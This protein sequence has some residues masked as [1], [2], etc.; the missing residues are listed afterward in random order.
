MRVAEGIITPEETEEV[1]R[2]VEAEARRTAATY[3]E[4]GRLAESI[5]GQQARKLA[6]HLGESAVRSR[7]IARARPRL[8]ER[9]RQTG[10][11]TISIRELAALWNKSGETLENA[12]DLIFGNTPMREAFDLLSRRFQRERQRLAQGTPSVLFLLSDGEP[13]DGDPLP[14]ASELKRSGVTIVSCFVTDEDVV[15]PRALFTASQPSWG[16]GARLMFDLASHSEP[17]NPFVD[18]LAKQGWT[19]PDRARLFLQVN[20]SD[21]LEEFVRGLLGYVGNPGQMLPLRGR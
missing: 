13:T 4:L 18:L 7:L 21:V 11:T 19:V 15:S 17:G 6:E 10:D 8:E 16:K 9:L 20:Q 12:S 3:G 2:E 14:L 1:K 5:F